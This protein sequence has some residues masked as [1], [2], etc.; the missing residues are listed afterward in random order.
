MQSTHLR[1][2][3]TIGIIIN[4]RKEEVV[5]YL[6]KID[7]WLE[8]SQQ[9][10][11][12]LVCTYQKKILPNALK[13]IR[14]CSEDELLKESHLILTLGGDGTILQAVQSVNNKQI[15][16]L[17]VNLGGL[18]FLADTP[19]DKMIHNLEA[20]LAGNFL[21]EDRIVLKCRIENSDETFYAFND[22][23]IDKSGFSRV[24]E[25]ITSVDGNL[26]NSCLLYTSPSPRD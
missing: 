14:E 8:A 4:P 13:H 9:G 3:P 17:G 21:I 20:F 5:Q 16:I 10:A 11:K 6:K 15:P 1:N 7:D 2:N 24:I 26:L 12:V 19:P 22:F 18:G 23:V 25:I